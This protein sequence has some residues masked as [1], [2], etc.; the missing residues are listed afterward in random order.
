MNSLTQTKQLL[1]SSLSR[2]RIFSRPTYLLFK[3]RAH[4]EQWT[5]GKE[6]GGESAEGAGGKYKK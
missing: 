4:N 3:W 1:L 6:E 5:D 2:W